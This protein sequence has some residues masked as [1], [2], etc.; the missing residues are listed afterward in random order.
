MWSLKMLYHF[1]A[2]IHLAVRSRACQIM[3][4]CFYSYFFYSCSSSPLHKIGACWRVER[5]S[6]SLILS[7]FVPVWA[8]MS[9]LRSPMVSSGLHLTRTWK[10]GRQEEG[11]EERLD[12][13]TRERGWRFVSLSPLHIEIRGSN[14]QTQVRR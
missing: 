2:K 9:F 1:S 11:G 5:D 8:A 10:E 6:R 7:A 13:K 12:D 4:S 3:H 14:T